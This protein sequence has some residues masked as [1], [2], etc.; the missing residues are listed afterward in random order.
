MTAARGYSRPQ[1]KSLQ[2]VEVPIRLSF[3]AKFCYQNITRTL[4][5]PYDRL[6]RLPLFSARV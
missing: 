5:L 1:R 3:D 6:A 4:R 2:D